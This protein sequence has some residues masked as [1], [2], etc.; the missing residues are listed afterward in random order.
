MS[1]RAL[2]RADS[3]VVLGRN[4]PNQGS[5]LGPQGEISLILNLTAG[6]HAAAE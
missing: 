4:S 2:Y 6:P 1:F 5:S 3:A